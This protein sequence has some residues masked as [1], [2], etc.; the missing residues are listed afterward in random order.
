M[1]RKNY[2]KSF[3]LFLFLHTVFFALAQKKTGLEAQQCATLPRLQLLLEKDPN[4]RDRFNA[5]Q[6]LLNRLTS[7][8]EKHRLLRTEAVVTIP[9]VFHILLPNPLL[10]TDA[11]VLAQLDTLNKAFGGTSGD[12][13]RIPGYFKPFYGK[14]SIQ[15][16]LAQRSP[17]GEETTGIIRKTVA[18]ATFEP[19]DAMKHASSGGSDSWN[20]DAYLNVWICALTG[21]VLGYATFPN[22]GQPAEQGVVIDYRSL[23][24]G[25]TANYN[26]GKT[27]VHETGHYFNLSHIW[28][29]DDGLC[30]GT[31]NVEDTPNQGN[32]SSGCATG[33]RTDNCTASGNGIMYQNYMDYSYDRCL[34]MFTPGQVARME[35]ALNLYRSSLL[36]SNGCLPVVRKAYDVQ[37]LTIVSPSQRLC[38]PGFVPAVVIRNRGS[39][40]LTSVTLHTQ[41][42][43]GPV[44]VTT[45]TGNLTSTASTTVTLPGLTTATGTHVLTIY[46]TNPNGVADEEK[47]NDTIRLQ[48]Q[49]Y[50]PVTTVQE[51]FEQS[52]FPPVGWD[53]VNPD[54][55]I[56]WQKVLGIAKTGNASVTIKNFDYSATG[57]KDDLRLPQV[58]IPT[59][60]DSVF[61]SFQVAAATYTD[62]STANNV[63][64]TLEVLVSTDCGVTYTSLYKKWGASL[65]TTSSPQ[66]SSFVP[67]AAE[68]RKDSINLAAYIGQSNLLLAFRNTTGYENN[69]YLDDV[70]LRTVTINPNLKKTGFLV[71][72][73]PTSGQLTVQFFPQPI[74]LRGLQVFNAMGQK[75]T[76]ISIGNGGGSN[77][78]SLDL[79]RYAA[80]IY[81][82]R[83]VFTDRVVVQKILKN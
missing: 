34:V 68:W 26:N 36:Q 76:E 38:A 43:N 60:V 72:P 3:F 7:Q 81:F 66:L 67:T 8:A 74:N 48:F 61:F 77:L 78:Y 53:I 80:G 51:S 9:V 5:D 75:L 35:T 19:D 64:D 70:N 30:T 15:F 47:I 12:S 62:L 21:G 18:R 25:S 56:T 28:G 31:D 23:P 20:T 39:Q 71:T 57:E 37:A 54:G 82:V 29:D 55:S 59:T 11:Q 50:L 33:I 79:S 16:C 32:S 42:D 10:V 27:L 69:I 83:A 4:R 65:V 40:T 44:T 2:T 45:W 14:S 58:N 52:G 73:N 46:T 6:A 1:N 13:V 41:I 63:W 17:D 24:G 22:D 49:Y